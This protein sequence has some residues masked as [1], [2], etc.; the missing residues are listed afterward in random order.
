MLFVF[1][2]AFPRSMPEPHPPMAQPKQFSY[3]GTL[4]RQI[5]RKGGADP[6]LFVMGTGMALAPVWKARGLCRP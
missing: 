3:N 6:R 5:P 1:K 4:C 2:N